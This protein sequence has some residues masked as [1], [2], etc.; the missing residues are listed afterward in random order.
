[1]CDFS[2]L[3]TQKL[4]IFVYPTTMRQ[5][6]HEQRQTI[7]HEIA[8]AQTMVTVGDTEDHHG[9]TWLEQCGRIMPASMFWREVLTLSAAT[10]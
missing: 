6:K 7:L 9:Q 8:H 1:M 3:H 5:S 10:R 4:D 2:C